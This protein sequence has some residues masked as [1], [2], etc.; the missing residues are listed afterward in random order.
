VR[1]DR[2]STSFQVRGARPRSSKRPQILFEPLRRWHSSS[3]L[4]DSSQGQK[5]TEDFGDTV[6]D[7]RETQLPLA[8]LRRLTSMRHRETHGLDKT[9]RAAHHNS[10]CPRFPPLSSNPWLPVRAHSLQWHSEHPRYLRRGP[11]KFVSATLSE[12][13]HNTIKSRAMTILPLNSFAAASRQVSS[14]IPSIPG[15]TCERT[16]V[17]T[18]A[19]CAIRPTSSTGV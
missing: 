17:L 5:A 14:G 6:R 19:C 8:P 18:P 7:Q 9:I 10:V 2:Y 12:H 3:G 13:A 1:L 15:T 11:K 4:P 16:S